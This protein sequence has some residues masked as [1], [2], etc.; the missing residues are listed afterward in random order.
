MSTL[1]GHSYN[2]HEHMLPV[3]RTIIAR[4]KIATTQHNTGDYNTEEYSC[5]QLHQVTEQKSTNLY[6]FSN[7]ICLLR[8]Y[9]A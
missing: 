2:D 6:D 4:A 3:M 7:G 1:A 5:L 9:S 8:N